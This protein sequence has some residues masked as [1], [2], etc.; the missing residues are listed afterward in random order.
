MVLSL[1]VHYRNDKAKIVGVLFEWDDISTKKIII[2]CIDKVEEY[3][4]GEFYK[5]ELPCLLKIIEKVDLLELEVIIIDGYIFIDNNFKY[6]LGGILWEKLDRKI[7]IIGVA[8]TSFFSNKE[9]VKELIRGNSKKPLYISTIDYPIDK[10][11]E[12]LKKMSGEYRLPTILKQ[13]DTITK[14]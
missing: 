14:E 3:V 11:M 9:T 2:E 10:A 12:N 13:M 4:S 6:G 1:D 5:R 8:K 7:P